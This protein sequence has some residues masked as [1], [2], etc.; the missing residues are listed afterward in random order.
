MLREAVSHPPS[1]ALNLDGAT[2]EEDGEGDTGDESPEFDSITPKRRKV[3]ERLFSYMS[4][5]GQSLL[6]GPLRPIIDNGA[7]VR[8]SERC[9]DLILLSRPS[10]YKRF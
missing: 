9:A 3:T 1:S 6:S 7:P 4:S 5:V 2:L 10:G 8:F